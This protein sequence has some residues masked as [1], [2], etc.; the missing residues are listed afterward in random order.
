MHENK[1]FTR[2]I[3]T[4]ICDLTTCWFHTLAVCFLNTGSPTIFAN[5]GKSQVSLHIGRILKSTLRYIRPV[6]SHTLRMQQTH[7]FLFSR[8]QADE[9]R[10]RGF[11]DLGPERSR[12]GER[13]VTSV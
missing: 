5:A 9:K 4:T 1:R 3:R 8:S 11:M 2:R 12:A 10:S 6:K 7:S 13:S